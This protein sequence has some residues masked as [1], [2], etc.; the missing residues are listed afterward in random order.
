MG[1]AGR[2]L[3]GLMLQ[4]EG[5]R[6]QQVPL[7]GGEGWLGGLPIPLVMMGGGIILLSS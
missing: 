6:K 2:A 4:Q 3:L 1:N 5:E 7:L